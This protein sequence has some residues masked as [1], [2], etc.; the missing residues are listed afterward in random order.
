MI[1]P[2]DEVKEARIYGVDVVQAPAPLRRDR[3]DPE[4]LMR[5]GYPWDPSGLGYC[6]S[7]V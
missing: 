6:H 7:G 5:L 1:R 3:L 2:K 4:V